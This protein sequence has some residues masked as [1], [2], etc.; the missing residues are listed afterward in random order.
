MNSAEHLADLE[1]ALR[2]LRSDLDRL[3]RWGTVI[4]EAVGHGG[5]LLAAGNGGSAAHAQHLTAELVGRY[6]DDRRPLSAIAL[7]ADTSALTAIVNDYGAEEAFARSVRAHGRPGDVLV[8]L[9]TSGRSSNVVAAAI[10]ARSLGIRTFALTG[11]GPNP[12]ALATDDAVC[13]EGPTPTVQE[14][15]QVAIHLVCAAVDAAIASGAAA[16]DAA[17]RDASS[18]PIFTGGASETR[19]PR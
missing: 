15:H 8:A 7:H 19:V 1:A 10:T 17:V 12:L 3:E 16:G 18:S 11:P 5:R 4:A 9:S 6:L 13:V 14:V 2:A